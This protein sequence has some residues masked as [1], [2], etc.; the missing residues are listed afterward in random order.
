MKQKRSP[1]ALINKKTPPEKTFAEEYYYKKQMEGKTVMVFMLTDGE[2]VRGS[3]EWYDKECLKINRQAHPNLLLR[4]D[5][6]KYM[7]KE[8]EERR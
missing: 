3:I 6:I 1:F 5:V 2:E 8:I 4:K 7:Y